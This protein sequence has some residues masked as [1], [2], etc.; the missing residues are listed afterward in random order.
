MKKK[1]ADKTA[2]IDPSTR[3]LRDIIESAKTGNTRDACLALQVVADQL[4]H[5][6]PD[7]A[8]EWLRNG[9][10]AGARG[11]S[12]N[13]ALGLVR[14]GR[15]NQW[16]HKAKALAVRA[17]QEAMQAQPHLSSEAVF[18]WVEELIGNLPAKAKPGD[19]AYFWVREFRGIKPK[20]EQIKTWYYEMTSEASR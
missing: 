5:G 20:A 3:H 17:A 6:L 11:D 15:Q 16:S 12:I 13:M 4:Q 19:D 7:Y 1:P 9:L 8:V 18:D 2:M 14:R 10:D